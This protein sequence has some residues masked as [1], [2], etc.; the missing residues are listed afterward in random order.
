MA[1][2]W[3]KYGQQSAPAN[4]V[5]APP[6][7]YKQ[8]AE[9]RA[10]QDQAIQQQR[11][12]IAMRAEDRAANAAPSGYRYNDAGTL[13][14]IPGGPADET[15]GLNDGDRADIRAEAQQKLALIDSLEQRSRDGW[16]ATG[17]GAS[18]ASA[19]PGTTAADVSKDVQ[20]L[21]AAGALQRIMEMAAANGGKNPLTPLSNADFIALGQSIANLD[22]SQS[23][24]Q[25]QRNLQ[26]Y[27]DIYRRALIAAGGS[28]DEQKRDDGPA[29]PPLSGGVDGGAP[30]P[31]AGPVPDGRIPGN[32]HDNGGGGSIS[33]AQG[34]TIQRDN[35]VLSGVRAEYLER[36]GRGDSAEQIIRWARE[37]G[38]HPRA[39][40]SIGKQVA[41]RRANPQVPLGEYNTSELDDEVVPLSAGEQALNAVGQS[42]AGAFAI[43][44]GDAASG[45]TLDEI[46]GA[47]GGDAERA[48][49]GMGMVADQNPISSMAGTLAGGSLMALGGEAA[50]G[51]RGMTAG[52]PRAL[53]ADSAYG[54][55][56]GAGG[57]D[58]GN[59]LIGAAQGAVAGATGSYAGYRTGNALAGLA[60]GVSDPSVNTLRQEG[61]NALTAGQTYGNSG[62]LGAMVQ[63][64]ENRL[65]GLP[66]VGEVIRERRSE[67]L[68]QFNSRG[69]DKAL[70]PI[71]G[72][73]GNLVGEEAVE[74]AQQ[75]VSQAFTAALAGKGAV[76]D[77]AFARD[78]TG[79]V[80]GVRSIKRIGDELDDE[81]A[82]IL[83]PYMN[84]PMLSGEA[85]DDISRNLRDLKG[86]YRNDPLGVRAAKQIDRVERAIFD[87]FD[88]QASGTIPEYMAARQAYR[89]VSILEDAVLK[90]RNQRDRMY[91]PAQLAQA[92]RANAKK[93]GGKRAAA[94]GDTPFH[95]YS[96]AGQDVLP[97]KVPDSGTAGRMVPLIP[98]ALVGGGGTADAAGL[99][100]TGTGLTI[101]TILAA[102][103]S[104]TGQRL[105]TKPGR[106]MAAGTKR[107]AAMESPATRRALGAAGA[108]GSAALLTGPE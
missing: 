91:T 80:M 86:R 27:R 75:Q 100:P 47:T 10:R 24:A 61:V 12:D 39:F 16:F 13:E 99:T 48:R 67:P 62:K 106:G 50:L 49:L 70:E 57:A 3:E 31:P 36:L 69:F 21:A 90:A 56:A 74:Q 33:L 88:R 78:L 28:P 22:P 51:A 37:V 43:N 63:G 11:L 26:A 107:R 20:T 68:R 89:R 25:F 79:A 35:P 84:G 45:F 4:P 60:R 105:L 93:F 30:P 9:Q 42:P 87:L 6:D 94:R 2:P 29:P 55:A 17:F 82:D 108:A 76:P 103:Y 18:T 77:Q 44:A 101:G 41:Y 58:G 104:K 98:L 92:D 7:P 23:D 15:G 64:V 81:V 5:I 96:N 71:G 38:I 73:V 52:L 59:R 40:S 46:I 53:A 97:N 8:A 83:E 14:P 85:L 72:T 102:L 65:E 54:A 32:T 1:G 19:I 95:D 34:E 66:I